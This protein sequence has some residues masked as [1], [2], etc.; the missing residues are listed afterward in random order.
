M[1]NKCIDCGIRIQ[2]SN[3]SNNAEM[4]V[5]LSGLATSNERD[6]YGL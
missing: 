4:A 3:N 2:F 6:V 5:I 1:K